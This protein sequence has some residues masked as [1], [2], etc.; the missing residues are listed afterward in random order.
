MPVNKSS[1]NIVNNILHSYEAR[2]QSIGSMF[3]STH[4]ILQGFQDILLNTRQEREKSSLELR[5]SLAKNES[6]RRKDFDSMMQNI[7]SI[8]NKREKEV[9]NL[10]NSYLN[11]QREMAQELRDNFIGFKESLAK[12]DAQRLNAFQDM[13]KEI[14]AKQDK[15]KEE[16]T[17]GLKE[18]QK[19]QNM[20]SARLKELVAK[21]KELRIRDFKSMLKE[22]ESQHKQRL[23][24]QQERKESVQNMLSTFKKKRIEAAEKKRLGQKGRDQTWNRSP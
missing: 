18:F 11:E 7:L 1:S 19:K 17:S 5:E 16:V 15:R 6:L 13:I 4:Q 10:L 9:R 23:T 14:I 24:H 3:D 22:F 21:G 2:I 20:L 8:Q 12:S